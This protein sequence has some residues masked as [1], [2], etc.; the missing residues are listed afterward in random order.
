MKET[1]DFVAEHGYALIAL[2]VFIEQIG[3]PIP[4]M[5]VLMAGGALAKVGRLDPFVALGISVVASSIA[6]GLWYELGRRRGGPVLRLLC[7]ISLE[8]D[9]CVRQSENVF[10]RWGSGAVVV[11]KF[12]PGLNTIAPPMAGV[13]R[14]PRYVFHT[15]NAVGGV[16]HFG[17]FILLGWVFGNQ[18]EEIV[19]YASTWGGWF[20]VALGL[21]LAAWIGRKW[22]QRRKFLRDHHTARITAGELSSRIEAG[23]LFSIIDLRHAMDFDSDP[24]MIPG[25]IHLPVEQLT[26]RVGEIPR[27]R[28]II[29]YCT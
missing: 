20:G 1:L 7:K 5:P 29:L 26:R 6:D 27:D 11:A 25:A 23:E 8:P 24:D 12:M 2:F 3:F 16:L 21:S 14:M 19:E 22:Y 17:L 15:L 9:S 4:A 18:I 28:E 13:V 10:E